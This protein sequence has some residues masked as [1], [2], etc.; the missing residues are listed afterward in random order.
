MAATRSLAVLVLAAALAAPAAAQSQAARRERDAAAAPGQLSEVGKGEHLARKATQPGAFI[1][2]RH[3]QA[4]EAYLARHHGPGKP[5]LPGFL[6]QGAKCRAADENAPWE[7]GDSLPPNARLRALP[8]G[9]LATLP[10]APPGNRYVLFS[11]DILLIAA[12]SRMVVDAMAL[13]H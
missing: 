9:L 3:R 11:G 8:P 4:A 10:S 13:R 5:C 12:E 7:I 2:P 1:T 6:Q